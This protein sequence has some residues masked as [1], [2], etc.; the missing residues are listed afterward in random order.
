[1]SKFSIQAVDLNG[2]QRGGI[3]GQQTDHGLQVE[4]DGSDGQVN[5]ALHS[6]L[7][8]AKTADLA[9]LAAR[10]WTSILTGSLDLPMLALDGSNGLKM[11]GALS[12]S[13]APGY[14]SGS[15]HQVRTGL[16]GLIYASGYRWSFPGYLEMSL[17]A[18]FI[19][20]DG[21]TDPI[22][23]GTSALPTQVLSTEKLTLDT[24]TAG[25]ASLGSV[26][27]VD[28]SIDPKFDFDYNTG[29]PHPV[30]I[31]G[32]GAKGHLAVRMEIDTDDL[33]L[34]E[35]TGA[36]SAVFR[37]ASG[38]GASIGTTGLS[39]TLNGAWSVEESEGGSQGSAKNRRLVVRTAKVGSTRPFTWSILS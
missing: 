28:V 26:R 6:I 11:Y 36:C 15:N 25:A 33:A 37:T 16:R 7:R 21:R 18:M 31:T 4:S 8:T 12:A 17:R 1:M 5:E 24:L 29:L 22:T 27:S 34:G 3:R 35:G 39:L 32:A 38:N 23:P 13:S 30:D 9:T 19:G 10:A 14:D 20:P 2:T